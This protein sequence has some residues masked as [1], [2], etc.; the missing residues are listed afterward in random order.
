MLFDF[1][2]ILLFFVGYKLYGIYA[3]TIIII[4][5]SLLQTGIFWLKHRKV[6]F[7]HITTLVLVLILGTA[8]ILLKNEMFIKW[9]PTA[10][11]WIF[12]MAFLGSQIIGKKTLIERLMGSKITLP[13]NVWQNLNISWAI[14]FIGMGVANIYI[15]YKFNTDIWVNFKLFGTLGGTLIFGILQSIYM[16]KYLKTPQE[17][18]NDF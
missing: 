17:E 10:I 13:K 14:F 2:P 7:M 12:S 6:E 18:Q 11:Y 15:A 9:K 3:A 4:I 5:A 8:T 1:L 16:A